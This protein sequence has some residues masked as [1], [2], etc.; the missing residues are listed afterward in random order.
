MVKTNQFISSAEIGNF[1]NYWKAYTWKGI[2]TFLVLIL[3]T[4]EGVGQESVDSSIQVK[5]QAPAYNAFRAK[6]NYT[7]LRNPTTNPYLKDFFD[8]V[9]FIPFNEKR[10][11]Y[12]SIGGEMRPRLEHFSNRKW[13]KEKVSFYSQRIS[14]HSNLVIGEKFRVF[15][16]LYHGFTSH[17]KQLPQY[18]VLDFHQLFIEL[19]FR[20]QGDKKVSLR[21][22]RQ[23]LKFGTSR[24]ITLREGPNIRQDFDLARAIIDM[25]K[26]NVQIFYGKEVR[27]QTEVFDNDFTLFNRDAPNANLWGAYSQFKL[28]GVTGSNELYYI[29]FHSDMVVLS[30]VAGE[31]TRHTIG[32]RRFGLIGK[33]LK[34]NTE[35]I[36]QFGKNNG[37][38][39]RAYNVETDWGYIISKDKWQLT[40]GLKLVFASGDK[41]TGDGKLETFNSLYVSPNVYNL[42]STLVPINLISLH[43]LITVQPNDKVKILF[44]YVFFWRMSANDHVYSP[45][46]RI[47]REGVNT[48]SKYLGNQLGLR[49][50]YKFNRHLSFNLDTSYY[51]AGAFQSAT[52]EAE[53]IF[54]IAPTLSYKF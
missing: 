15:A 26:I 45:P 19:P 32:L 6:E 2:I 9:K 39:I 50:D 46:G 54:H 33:R 47:L 48:G 13:N 35:I 17:A 5:K 12:F 31:E 25:E 14:F 40:P 16:E 36:Y 18:D 24:L 41:N 29:G 34:Y 42:A 43:P 1:L 22:G 44:E 21:F 28:K 11:A 53:N 49:L 8:P 10:D 4:H 23:E 52:G 51:I 30:D 7:Y 27:T 38:D 20:F 3:I 37:N